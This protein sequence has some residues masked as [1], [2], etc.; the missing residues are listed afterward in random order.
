MKNLSNFNNISEHLNANEFPQTKTTPFTVLAPKHYLDQISFEAI[1]ND[2]IQWDRD[3]WRVPPGTLALSIVLTPFFRADKRYPLCSVEEIVEFMD[4]ELVFGVDYPPSY[5]N[6]HCLGLLLDRVHEAGCTGLFSMIVSQVFAKFRIPFGQIFQVD[7]TSHVYY[8]DAKV[9]EEEN[10]EGLKVTYGYSKDKRP[11]K[12]QVMSGMI[13]NELGIPL[14]TETL[15]GNTA[16]TVWLPDAMRHFRDLFGEMYSDSIFIADS[17]LVSKNNFGIFFDKTNP[18]NFISRCPEKFCSRIA[19]KT[20]EEA[21]L[22]DKWEYVGPCCKDEESKRA[23]KYEVQ[24]FEKIVHGNEC[25]LVVFRNLDGNEK[26]VNEINKEREKIEEGIKKEFKKPFACEADARK[27][28][29]EFARK[30]KP[31][32]FNVKFEIQEETIEKRPIGRPSKSQQKLEIISEFYVKL[33]SLTQNKEKLE[34]RCQSLETVVLITNVPSNTKNDKEIFQLY[35]NQQVVETNFEELKK[36]SMFYR[37]FLEKPERI[38][39]LLML[40][41]VSLLVRV[42]MRITARKNLE[43][44]NE[45]LR[46]D[47]GRSILKNPTAEKMLRLLSFH[48][49]MTIDGKR[50]VIA[51]NGKVDLLNKLLQL[52]DLNLESG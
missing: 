44:E 47:F 15:D 41:H 35:K 20:V 42:L 19:E 45:P 14:Y 26:L 4:A 11:D 23:T 13:T 1:I 24:G 7:T 36:P 12:K 51:K 30:Y 17:K 9:C 25:R 48:Y 50:M 49:V 29:D 5:F 28:M 46:I 31:S 10:Y 52:L 18:F 39:A 40:L 3:Q 8:G 34:K 38:E 6:D 27:A 43:K 33:K 37:I 32:L 21:Y 16:D 2:N 22:L